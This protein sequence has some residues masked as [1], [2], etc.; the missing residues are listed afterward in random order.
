MRSGQ[1]RRAS[2]AE[3]LHALFGLYHVWAAVHELADFI[4]SEP[5]IGISIAILILAGALFAILIRRVRQDEF[6][7]IR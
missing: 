7:H 1:D 5:R 4:R 6:P 3:I 2:V